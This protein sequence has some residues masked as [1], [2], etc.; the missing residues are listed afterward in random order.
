M[1]G[2]NASTFAPV[3]REVE[4]GLSLPIPA[5]VQI[6]RELSAD[7]E[8][9][10]DRFVDDG[11]PPDE[12]RTMALEALV[13]NPETLR[14]LG[15][16]HS[17]L[18]RRLTRRMSTQRVRKV[19]RSL[20]VL[21]TLLVLLLQTVTLFRAN[22]LRGPSLFLVAVLLAGGVICGLVIRKAFRFWIKK[23]HLHPR[24]GL[25]V[26][27]GASCLTLGL[28]I[29][30]VVFD[31]YWLAV[32]LERSPHLAPTLVPD[33]LV[34]NSTLLSVA[35]LIALSG[36]LAWFVLSQWL[37]RVSGARQEILGSSRIPRP[38]KGGM[39]NG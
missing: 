30:G 39:Q 1:N 29:G 15:E 22:L 26:I 8:E 27:L 6:L 33:S 35:I 11:V 38:G 28:G 2:S 17:P 3:L 21:S 20:L 25:G 37:A 23:D 36:G 32:I 34:R 18:Y 12:A 31:F 4:R 16:L 10:M 7:L 19:E 13:P 5:R 14:T 24:S 9:L